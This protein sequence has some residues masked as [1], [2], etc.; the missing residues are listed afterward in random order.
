MVNVEVTVEITD[1]AA[2]VQQALAKMA[3]A[4]FTGDGEREARREEIISDPWAAVRWLVDPFGLLPAVSGARIVSAWD[5]ITEVNESGS[6]R[7]GR[8]DF[9]A[10][11]PVCRCGE[12]ACDDCGGYQLT[13]RTAAVLWTVAAYESGA[14]RSPMGSEF[15]V[16]RPDVRCLVRSG[17]V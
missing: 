17:R 11:F 8:P 1:T 2:L 10:L 13:P 15:G 4:E 16:H 12:D 7:R 6:G 5:G 14:F 3:E 9:V